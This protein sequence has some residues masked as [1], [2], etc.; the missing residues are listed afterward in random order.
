MKITKSQLR[1]II[2]E[3]LARLVEYG[4]APEPAGSLGGYGDTDLY[5]TGDVGRPTVGIIETRPLVRAIKQA[6]MTTRGSRLEDIGTEL[7]SHDPADYGDDEWAYAERDA[8]AANFAVGEL[9]EDIVIRRQR[10]NLTA[11][12]GWYL[13]EREGAVSGEVFYGP[14]ASRE[15]AVAYAGELT[16]D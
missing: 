6:I 7:V 5:G 14:F 8:M 3:E 10:R 15:E 12:A 2:K 16:Q 11:S 13:Y 9:L 4:E 1:Q